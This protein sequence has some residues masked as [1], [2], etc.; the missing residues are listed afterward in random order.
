MN[1]VG[2]GLADALG[3]DYADFRKANFTTNEANYYM[4]SLVHAVRLT[5]I[6]E[7]GE[8]TCDRSE[9]EL[10]GSSHAV[11]NNVARAIDFIIR[12]P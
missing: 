12:T 2:L 7:V 3:Y 4:F 1:F 5:G 9:R 6:L 10:I 8:L 11:G